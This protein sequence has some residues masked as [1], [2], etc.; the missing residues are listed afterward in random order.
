MYV[1]VMSSEFY[2]NYKLHAL[3]VLILWCI[4]LHI[5]MHET[6]I[7]Y[8]HLNFNMDYMFHIYVKINFINIIVVKGMHLGNS[9]IYFIG[10]CTNLIYCITC[11]VR[12]HKNILIL[13]ERKLFYFSRLKFMWHKQNKFYKVQSSTYKRI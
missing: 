6:H 12:I 4:Y 5:Y 9:C 8:M 11:V 13:T 3:F 1:S 2:I 10:T 7:Y